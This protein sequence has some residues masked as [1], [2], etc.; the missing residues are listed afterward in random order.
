VF[1]LFAFLAQ[2]R[3][4]LHQ[5]HTQTWQKHCSRDLAA[6]HARRKAKQE[7]RRKKASQLQACAEV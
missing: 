5:R 3:R 1:I 2:P 4:A 7:N 6:N